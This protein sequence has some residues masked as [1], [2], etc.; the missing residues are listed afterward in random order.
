MRQEVHS[1]EKERR[2][3]DRRQ[4]R[5][6]LVLHERRSGFDRRE[7]GGANGGLTCV[8]S[9]LRDRPGTLWVLLFAVNILNLADFLLTLNVLALGGGEANP[10]LRALFAASPAYAGLFKFSAVLIVTLIVWR[11]RR[12][13]RA[14]EAALIMVGVFAVVFFYH[15]FG[16]LAYY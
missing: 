2:G 6:S 14:L 16:L 10:V 9:G 5:V 7:A 11:C 8:L 4:R 12:F 1:T 13:R 15:V 3:A